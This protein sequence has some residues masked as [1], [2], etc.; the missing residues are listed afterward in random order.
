LT[1]KPI[2]KKQHELTR[3]WIFG[4]RA[5]DLAKV[6][7]GYACSRC[8]EEFDTRVD[9]CPV[10]GEPAVPMI[11]SVARELLVVVPTPEGW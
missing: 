7:A 10:C 6:E 9:E 3:E 11:G 1:L 5:A 8:L 4:L 2:W